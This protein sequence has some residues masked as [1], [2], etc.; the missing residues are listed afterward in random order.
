MFGT[1]TSDIHS[2]TFAAAVFLAVTVGAVGRAVATGIH[3]HMLHEEAEELEMVAVAVVGTSNSTVETSSFETE[4]EEGE[5]VQ[6]RRQVSTMR[7]SRCF[8][9]A[10]KV[11]QSKNLNA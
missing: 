4:G 11:H 2:Y 1:A 8:E 3:S 9:S 7:E 6:K 10:E 5:E